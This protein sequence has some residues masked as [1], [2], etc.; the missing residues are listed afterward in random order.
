MFCPPLDGKNNLSLISEP[1]NLALPEPNRYAE[2][3]N[4]KLEYRSREA[5]DRNKFEIQKFK[6]SKP[7]KEF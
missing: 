4:P 1:P 2:L 6:N 5:R 7:R 3:K